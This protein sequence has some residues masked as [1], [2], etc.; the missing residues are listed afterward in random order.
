MVQLARAFPFSSGHVQ[1]LFP[2]LFRSMPDACY[3]RERFETSDGDFVDLDWSRGEGSPG[4][5]FIMHGLEGHSRRKYVLG[6]VR[7]AR[8]HGLDAVAMNFRG[9]SG[10]PNRKVSMYH[11]GWTRDLHE[12]LLMIASLRRYRSVH[13][14][15]FSLGGNVILKYLGEDASII[16][17][18]VS[19][20]VAISVPCDLEDSARALARPQC[21]LYTRYLLDQL[22]K[23]IIDKGRL[24]PGALD[25]K[26]VEKLRTFRQFDDRF[27]A[28]LHGF[29]D[30]LDY[31][32]RSSSR[33]YLP[34]IDR[35]TCII[36]A[37]NDP[38]LGPRCYPEGEARAN[39]NLTLLTPPTGGHVGFVGSGGGWMYWSE[40]MA[41]RFLLD[42]AASQVQ[43]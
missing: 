5:V 25:L 29:R 7:A 9:C 30:A 19:G 33:Q 17:G 24:F 4:L 18:V 34:G 2:P 13:L 27:T 32:R 28:P 23:K 14:I 41:M 42:P 3:E 36:N 16:P 39:G 12:A 11:S 38:F 20:A 6:M 21:A 15:G 40:W 43:E 31:W 37:A 8:E 35:R 22:R 1:T 26:G 10:E